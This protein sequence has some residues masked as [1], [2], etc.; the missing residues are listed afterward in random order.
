MSPKVDCLNILCFVPVFFKILNW[1]E[2]CF[3][4]WSAAEQRTEHKF[5]EINKQN[6]E[7]SMILKISIIHFNHLASK[8]V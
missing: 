8:N 2:Q 5:K 4:S 3:L 6:Y 7:T 1:L